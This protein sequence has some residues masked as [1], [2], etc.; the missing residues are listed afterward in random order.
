MLTASWTWGIPRSRDNAL[1]NLSDDLRRRYSGHSFFA[2]IEAQTLLY[3]M[4]ASGADLTGAN[5]EKVFPRHNSAH[6][7]GPL[8]RGWLTVSVD[9]TA[10]QIELLNAQSA[11][12]IVM[13]HDL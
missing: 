3:G 11:A 10:T 1:K 12:I 2:G 13:G 4:D 7:G 8:Q 5:M 6:Q 9:T